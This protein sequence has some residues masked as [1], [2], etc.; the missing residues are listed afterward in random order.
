M[1]DWT[2]WTN[3][4]EKGAPTRILRGQSPYLVLGAPRTRAYYGDRRP[5]EELELRSLEAFA[6][7]CIW[8]I[9]M[10]LLNL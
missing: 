4:D 6:A 9:I 10:D 2:G 5:S 3:Y 1:N 8:M 7:V